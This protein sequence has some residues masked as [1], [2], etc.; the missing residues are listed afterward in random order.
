MINKYMTGAIALFSALLSTATFAHITLEEPGAQA[1]SMY[2]AVFRITHGCEGSPTRSIVV[3]LPPGV[4][5]AK[6]MPKAGWNLSIQKEK[7][8]QPYEMH[9]KKIDERAAV[10]EWEGGRLQDSE[11]DE[12]VIRMSLPAEPGVVRF[13]ILQKCE[14]GEMDW[15]ATP[16]IDKPAPKY[17]APALELKPAS[18]PAHHH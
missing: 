15:A 18:A 17:P 9:G 3:Y 5:G 11:Y 8:A 10:I 12:F 1:G 2:K 6:P 13:R 4:V 16:A 14:Q 7:L